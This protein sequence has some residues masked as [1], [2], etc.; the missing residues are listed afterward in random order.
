MVKTIKTS[1]CSWSAIFC[2][3][4]QWEV[5]FQLKKI[6]HNVSKKRESVLRSIP[7]M[8]W[9][10]RNVV[11][12]SRPPPPPPPPT[13]THETWDLALY[14]SHPSDVPDTYQC[15]HDIPLMYVLNTSQCTHDIPHI[16]HDIPSMYWTS[17]NVFMIFPTWIMTSLWWTEHPLMC[18]WYPP[19]WI[20]I[21]LWCAEHPPMYSRYPPNA[22]V[23]PPNALMISPNVLNTHYTGWYCYSINHCFHWNNTWMNYKF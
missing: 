22:F 1:D 13:H 18:S 16:N 10:S 20:M 23:I 8:Y 15:T 7:P 14:S 5:V 3:V 6:W 4:I 9:T 17:S 12:T 2:V 11:M 21:S 19:P